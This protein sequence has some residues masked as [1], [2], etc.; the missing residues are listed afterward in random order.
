M[1]MSQRRYDYDDDEHVCDYLSSFCL[2]CGLGKVLKAKLDSVADATYL[3][4]R[5]TL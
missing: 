2:Q 1:L 5:A 4:K 3:Y